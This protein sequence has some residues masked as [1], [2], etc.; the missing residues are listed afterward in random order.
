MGQTGEKAHSWL[1]WAAE[2]WKATATGLTGGE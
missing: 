1:A 2:T